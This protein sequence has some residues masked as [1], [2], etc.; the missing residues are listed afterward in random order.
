MS[1]GAPAAVPLGVIIGSKD[2]EGVEVG[3]VEEAS[4]VLAL[5]TNVEWV[6]RFKVEGH[7]KPA[8]D[9]SR[10][11]SMGETITQLRI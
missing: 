4:L 7:P 11:F 2:A 9:A 10:L 8:E 3:F 6:P 1:E 5:G